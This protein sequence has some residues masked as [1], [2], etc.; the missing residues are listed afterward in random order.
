M[1][2]KCII[3]MFLKW[4]EKH[5]LYFTPQFVNE[6]LMR[7]LSKESI[8]NCLYMENGHTPLKV[9]CPVLY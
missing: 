5:S 2:L 8:S 3:S 7:I 9:V 6:R 1:Y 4:S